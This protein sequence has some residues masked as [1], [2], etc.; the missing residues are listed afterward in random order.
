M[1]SPSDLPDA[2]CRA[3]DGWRATHRDLT[4]GDVL[5]ALSKCSMLFLPVA[6]CVDCANPLTI[7]EKKYYE[8]RCGACEELWLERMRAGPRN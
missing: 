4:V 7:E 8:F 5:R 6:T 2:I 1:V 3:I